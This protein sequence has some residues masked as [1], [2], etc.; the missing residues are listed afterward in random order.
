VNA[1]QIDAFGGGET[2]THPKGWHRQRKP[3]APDLRTLYAREVLGMPEG[4]EWDEWSRAEDQV[5]AGFFKLV[6]AVAPRGP[7]TGAPQWAKRDRSTE[8][9]LFIEYA[10]WEQWYKERAARLNECVECGGTGERLASVSVRDG[11]WYRVCS[12]CGG[13]GKHNRP[14]VPA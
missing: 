12:R 6:G 14:E 8:R 10:A 13:D 4:W 3:D 9:T 7:R 11:A 1:A 5:P 2:A